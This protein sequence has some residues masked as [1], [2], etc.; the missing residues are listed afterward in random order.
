[1]VDTLKTL[2]HSCLEGAIHKINTQEV[3]LNECMIVFDIMTYLKSK[4]NLS[5]LFPYILYSKSKI[6]LHSR[7]T[8]RKEL[9]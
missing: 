5:I 2:E 8:W 9:N 1:M 3:F 6:F 7:K 4:I